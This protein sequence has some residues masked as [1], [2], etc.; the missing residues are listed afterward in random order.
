M[1]NPWKRLPEFN[2]IRKSPKK[3]CGCFRDSQWRHG[4]FLNR[5]CRVPEIKFYILGWGHG[6]LGGRKKCSVGLS[7][8]AMY[9]SSG[10]SFRAFFVKTPRR[11]NYPFGTTPFSVDTAF[12]LKYLHNRAVHSPPTSLLSPAHTS[13]NAEVQR[14]VQ[15]RTRSPVQGD[16]QTIPVTPTVKPK[17]QK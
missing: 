11:V 10:N 13:I 8:E 2:E 5:L 17:V 3:V 6:V 7:L 16:V 15:R 4:F 9:Q 12:P 1:L 14:E